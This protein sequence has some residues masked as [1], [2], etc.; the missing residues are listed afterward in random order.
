MAQ[1]IILIGEDEKAIAEMYKIAF[2]Q[3]GFQVI[4]AYNGNEVIELAKK[5]QPDTILLDINMPDKDGF[6]VLKE[7]TTDLSLFKILEKTPIIM[8]SNYSNARDINFCMENGAQDYLVKAEWEPK[9]IVE[10]VKRYLA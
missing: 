9:N 7:A 5:Y 4:S 8:L 3:A 10:K 1:K 6:Q 2:E